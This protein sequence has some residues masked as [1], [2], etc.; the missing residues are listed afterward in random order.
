M[1]LIILLAIMP[2]FIIALIGLIIAAILGYLLGRGR[3]SGGSI[4]WKSKFEERDA[5]YEKQSGSLKNTKNKLKKIEAEHQDYGAQ[6]KPLKGEIQSLQSKIK[7]YELSLT[8]KSS[9]ISDLEMS[10]SANS[11]L[12]LKEE[13][14]S[15]K[16][17]NIE[18]DNKISELNK[19]ISMSS[20]A[21]R[22]SELERKLNIANKSNAK[23]TTQIDD[24]RVKYDNVSPELK[25]QMSD[26]GD[27]KIA[28]HS[29][30]AVIKELREKL[31]LYT[32]DP[33]KGDAIRKVKA[34]MDAV[35]AQ[36]ESMSKENSDLK[37]ELE[38]LKAGL[39]SDGESSSKSSDAQAGSDAKAD[40]L[41]A[42]VAQLKS[43]LASATST[44]NNDSSAKEN[45]SLKSEV[46]NL[47]KQLNEASSA[48]SNSDAGALNS[49]K[50]E[51]SKSNNLKDNLG[52][53][54][55]S[56]KAEIEA[57]KAKANSSGSSAAAGIAN[58][59]GGIVQAAA[60]A[61]SGA[62]AAAASSVTDNAAGGAVDKKAATLARIKEKA[63]D[64][65]FNVIGT[66]SETDKDDLQKINGIG[67]F[68]ES[69]LNAL[70]IFKFEQLSKMSD[71]IVDKV[72][73]AIEFFPGRAKRDNWIGQAKEL[74]A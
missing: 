2:P 9:L 68:I 74:M 39:I 1:K 50:E 30:D 16:L 48:S 10:S 31:D 35:V 49:L 26:N 36:K 70:G 37:S 71:E 13:M 57:L 41:K 27:L 29:K 52:K 14:Q 28:M 64:L 19:T 32:P 12:A 67:P 33:E 58:A 22:A 47:K 38:K 43:K 61:L 73:D 66:A 56:L 6:I 55:V 20:N 8:E 5:A 21:D 42:E 7:D 63:K 51:L 23:L 25:K 54:N 46:A 15:L 34:D 18:K 4:D 72:N 69:K 60:G 24:W 11:E 40:A 53:E 17:S 3:N 59:G 44:S 62:A 65:D 45:E